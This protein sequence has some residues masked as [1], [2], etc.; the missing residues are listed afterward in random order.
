MISILLP[1]FNSSD[2][3]SMAIHSILL[4]TMRDFE[5]IILDDGSTDDSRER[6][7]AIHDERIRYLKLRHQGLPLTLNYGLTIARFGIVA[8]IDAGE[9]ALPERLQRQF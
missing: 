2:T 8:R 5:L 4:Q 6:V 7:S 1:T 9:I 3:L